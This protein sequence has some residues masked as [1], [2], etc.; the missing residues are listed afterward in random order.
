[1][2]ASTRIWIR[3]TRERALYWITSPWRFFKA[4]CL[5]VGMVVVTSGSL[6][7]IWL[8]ALLS[9]LPRFDG[10]EFKD[11]KSQAQRSVS[12]RIESKSAR[13]HKWLELDQVSRDYLYAIVL[14]ED[15]QFFDHDGIDFD[16]MLASMAENIKSKSYATGASTITQQVAKNVFLSQQKTLGRKLQ[17]LWLARKLERHFSKNQILEIYFNVAELGPDLFGMEGAA[18]KYFGK[19]SRQIIAP[20]GAFIAQ[21]LPSPRRYAYSMVE[22]LN[23]TPQKRRRIRRVLGD[24]VAQEW[25]SPS[26]YQAYV[27]YPFERKVRRDPASE[28]WQR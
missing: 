10:L 28:V 1:M 15:A 24:M 22:N 12:R 8:L 5:A 13:P 2:R 16:A 20:E 17:E 25:I 4:V 26:Q 3:R 21:L 23:L 14:S 11:L 19:T 27:K 7:L 9:Q 18:Q 6:V